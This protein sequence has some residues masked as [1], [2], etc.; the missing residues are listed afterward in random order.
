MLAEE[1]PN[2]THLAAS[3]ILEWRLRPQRLDDEATT[4][5]RAVW[6]EGPAVGGSAS[7]AGGR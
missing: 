4:F 5:A 2:A 7:R 1:L 6:G 3:S